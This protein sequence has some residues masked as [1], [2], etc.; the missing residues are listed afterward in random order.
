MELNNKSYFSIKQKTIDFLSEVQDYLFPNFFHDVSNQEAI[1]EKAKV[2]FLDVI[3]NDTNKQEIFFSKLGEIKAKLEEDLQATYDGDPAAT[4]LE[5]I[6]ITYPG[7]FAIIVYRLA[8]EL[9]L[10]GEKVSARIMSEFA[11]SRTGID[12]HPGAQIGRR[13]FIDHGTGVV[14]GETAIIGDNAKIYQGVTVGALSLSDGHS[15]NGKKRHPTLGNN[16]TVYAN[17]SIL[18]GETIIGNNVTIGGNTFIMKS[19]PDN[20]TVVNK[21]PEL[22]LKKKGMN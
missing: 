15:L 2:D 4:G 10:L 16:V 3:V 12:I 1:L 19:I 21:E 9:Y 11:H 8:H 18:G 20:M 17:A 13:F 5:E 22:I 6:L 14:I 7:A